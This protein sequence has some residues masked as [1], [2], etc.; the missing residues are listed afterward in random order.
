MSGCTHIPYLE[1]RPSGYFFRRRFPT[2]LRKI[3]NL[4]HG[5]F[6]CLSLR[7]HVPQDAKTLARA[8]TAL[9][10]L[11]FA[12]TETMMTQITSEHG[13]LLIELARFEIEAHHAL[14]AMADPRSDEAAHA[15]AAC[16]RAT[17]DVLRRA[18]ARGDRE[19][20]RAPLRAMAAR[21]GISLAEETM[22]WRV[23]AYEALKVMLDVAGERERIELGHYDGPTLF[24]RAAAIARTT[25][26]QASGAS[27]PPQTFAQA[28]PIASVTEAPEATLP[29]KAAS[30][31]DPCHADR[32][33]PGSIPAAVCAV[34]ENPA[35]VP[36][37]PPS[38]LQQ[39]PLPVVTA[40]AP[41]PE[42]VSQAEIAVAPVVNPGSEPRIL[43]DQSKL[44]DASRSALKKGSQISFGEAF[45]LY[46]ELKALG[47]DDLF[48]KRQKSNEKIGED[49]VKSSKRGALMAKTIWIDL[50]GDRPVSDIDWTEA[51]EALS[52]MLR[53]PA[54]HG[55]Q[56]HLMNTAGFLDL[57]ERA[58]E[59]EV[60]T[61]RRAVADLK[62]Q[63]KT[64]PAELEQARLDALVPRLSVATFLKHGR[65]SNRV[66]KMLKAMRL[67]ADNP[68]EIC[69]WTNREMRDLKAQEEDR[70]RGIWDDRIYDLLA[71]PVF[72][73]QL[74]EKGDP[75]FWVPLMARL[76]GGRSEE[77]LQLGPKDFGYEDG[78]PYYTIRNS[79]GNS[80]KSTAG[81]R[82][83]P[84]HQ[85]LIDLGLMRLVALRL[86]QNQ[87]RLFPDLK[88]GQTKGTFTELYT[89]R[90][91]YYRKKHN[92]YWR[93]LDLH[94]LRT[95]FHNDLANIICPDNHRLRLMGHESFSDE[96][97]RSYTKKIKIKTL[98][99][100]VRQIE[101]DV[102][103][104]VSPF[105]DAP[106]S[107]K[108]RG[109]V[110]G[111]RSVDSLAQAV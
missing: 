70:S 35:L 104:V 16:Q 55:K 33:D 95:T 59:H 76:G 47:Y 67:I 93:G 19:I 75:L 72:Q 107:A 31:A 18:L 37:Q 39:A 20:M 12:L 94:A 69:A 21:L 43:I 88:R 64:T 102:S 97:D 24:F 80:V 15:A 86:H 66:G 4:N 7:T 60:Q 28:A 87:P 74:D 51:D 99:E 50:L 111:I 91:G 32:A 38:D 40:V 44:T 56:P 49:W 54:F 101:L 103:N 78:I 96:G 82:R 3:T 27:Q 108:E 68:F 105:E 30:P 11:A 25:A 58:D 22:E 81:E 65:M 89:K 2:R 85:A 110:L 42:P 34:A 48:E 8:L 36:A 63:A 29:C 92:C 10:E 5:S 41:A 100:L 62:R 23:L 52:I 73:G 46:I 13:Q 1:R 17:Q 9:T 90:F 45:D 84:V 61:A 6:L 79:E 57:V 71:T 98:Y 83:I 109:E 14:R 77:L 53:I 26:P 106:A